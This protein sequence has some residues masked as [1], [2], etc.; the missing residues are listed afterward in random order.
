MP[1]KI[2]MCV[3]TLFYYLLF[4]L[5]IN[6]MRKWHVEV[7]F[8][9]VPFCWQTHK[10]FRRNLLPCCIRRI[11]N[12]HTT[13]KQQIWRKSYFLPGNEMYY[14]A[15]FCEISFK[16]CN[17]WHFQKHF[18]L[19]ITSALQIQTRFSKLRMTYYRLLL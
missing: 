8:T 12:I 4:L 17:C 19:D 3:C 16:S 10:T 15:S 11:Q 18:H 1:E 7:I 9:V 14:V 2:R 6:T 13:L 5:F